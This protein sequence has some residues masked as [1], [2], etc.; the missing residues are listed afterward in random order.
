PS[1]FSQQ[2]IIDAVTTHVVCGAQA[3]LVTED[4]TFTN[5]LV[6][7]R[8]KTTRSELPTRAKVKTNIHNKFVDFMENVQ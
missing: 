4:V 8:P 1:A 6:V 7:M 2:G 5:C 3:L